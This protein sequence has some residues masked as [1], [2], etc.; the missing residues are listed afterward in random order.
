MDNFSRFFLCSKSSRVNFHR[1]VE[2]MM[3]VGCCYY[4]CTRCCIKC[5]SCC[6][7]NNDVMNVKN[8]QPKHQH[9]KNNP[10]SGYTVATSAPNSVSVMSGETLETTPSLVRKEV[11]PAREL[12]AWVPH[13]HGVRNINTST[14]WR[15]KSGQLFMFSLFVTLQND[16][17]FFIMSSNYIRFTVLKCCGWIASINLIPEVFRLCKLACTIGKLRKPGYRFHHQFASSFF[18]LRNS[19]DILSWRLDV[20]EICKKQNKN[21]KDSRIRCSKTNN[22]FLNKTVF[23]TF[24]SILD[25]RVNSMQYI[26]RKLHA[27]FDNDRFTYKKRII[28][29]LWS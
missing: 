18:F 28:Y 15:T 1:D 14:R 20:I 9:I 27:Y 16:Y 3:E 7:G 11:K 23:K 5:W 24:W 29:P 12:N 25:D 6:Q 8:F 2:E 10:K 4:C 19:S 26:C 13:T 17:L 21:K 22:Q